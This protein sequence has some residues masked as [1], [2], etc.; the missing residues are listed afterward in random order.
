MH[1]WQGSVAQLRTVY[2]DASG[3]RRSHGSVAATHAAPLHSVHCSTVDRRGIAHL[4]PGCPLVREHLLQL[5]RAAHENE[6]NLSASRRS[7][8]RMCAARVRDRGQQVGSCAQRRVRATCDSEGFSGTS[9]ARCDGAVV[10]CSRAD[11][12]VL[13]VAD[14]IERRGARVLT[15]KRRVQIYTGSAEASAT[16][17]RALVSADGR[18]GAHGVLEYSHLRTGRTEGQARM[19]Y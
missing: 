3:T 11:G 17:G 4:R 19:G 9:S 8:R 15:L 13:A 10:R 1:R 14:G 18:A 5:R 6:H 2:V 12:G 16:L 7:L